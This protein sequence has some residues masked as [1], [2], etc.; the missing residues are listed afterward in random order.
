VKPCPH[1]GAEIKEEAIRCRYCRRDLIA[2]APAAGLDA[3]LGYS[4][5]GHRHV[6]G[7][8]GQHY[9]I[10]DRRALG[11]PM[12]A[13]P[14]TPEGWSQAWNHFLVMEPRA[15]EVPV[16]RSPAEGPSDYWVSTKIPARVVVALVAVALC[17]LVGAAIEGIVT[18]SM[19]Q[20]RSLSESVRLSESSAGATVFTALAMAV[21]IVAGVAWVL[22]Q[23]R[24]HVNL[25]SLGRGPW[26]F[27]PVWSVIGWLLPVANLVLPPLVMEELAQSA[28]LGRSGSPFDRSAR[29]FVIVWWATLVSSL[30]LFF[31]MGF[32]DPETNPSASSIML[33]TWAVLGAD[34]LFLAA[35]IIAIGLV[36]GITRRVERLGHETGIAHPTRFLIT[37]GAL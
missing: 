23:H 13:F 35:G 19:P 32:K 6:L 10:W 2:T 20:P 31:A 16:D 34:A 29:A 30:T 18:V 11:E 1:C 24:A 5:S 7:W 28:V 9:A 15:V 12:L 25:R 37:E 3:V 33:H 36:T 4:H 8:T 17:S 21:A 26:R 14:R 27:R 22:W